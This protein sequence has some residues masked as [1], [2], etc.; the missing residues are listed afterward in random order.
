[1]TDRTEL[2]NLPEGYYDICMYGLGISN[3]IKID[4]FF[5]QMRVANETEE[6]ED[7]IWLDILDNIDKLTENTFYEKMLRHFEEKI[8]RTRKLFYESMRTMQTTRIF[9]SSD[10]ALMESCLQLL[11]MTFVVAIQVVAIRS[12]FKDFKDKAGI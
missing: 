7:E 2:T 5:F 3:P 10:M 8:L 1:L 4:L 9:H 6:Y 11:V 12:F